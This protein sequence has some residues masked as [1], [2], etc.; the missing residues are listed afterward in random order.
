MLYVLII[1]LDISADSVSHSYGPTPEQRHDFCFA[2]VWDLNW[3]G[4][5]WQQHGILS[6]SS[7]IARGELSTFSFITLG[8]LY[9]S[10][11]SSPL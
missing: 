2:L 5:S 11:V 6:F 4:Q 3:S 10:R 7:H 8:F 1:I 9:T